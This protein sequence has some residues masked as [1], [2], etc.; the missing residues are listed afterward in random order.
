MSDL[1]TKEQF[2]T[3]SHSDVKEKYPE[4]EKKILSP[5][6]QTHIS[7]FSDHERIINVVNPHDDLAVCE[8]GEETKISGS[9]IPSRFNK[10]IPFI[11]KSIESGCVCFLNPENMELE[12]VPGKMLDNPEAFYISSGRSVGQ[13]PFQHLIWN[14]CLMFKPISEEQLQKLTDDFISSY[15]GQTGILKLVRQIKKQKS[16]AKLEALMV[17]CGL[18]DLWKRHKSKYFER[19][20]KDQMAW[21]LNDDK[22]K[23][24]EA[25]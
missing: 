20:I 2:C 5:E 9:F 10:V 19:I 1:L 4:A 11:A 13:K 17:K 3:S 12:Q 14:H 15:A 18:L 22:D 7:P 16:F 21:Y 6:L 23:K 25:G 24:G 8:A